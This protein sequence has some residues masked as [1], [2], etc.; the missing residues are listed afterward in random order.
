MKEH[1]KRDGEKLLSPQPY[2]QSQGNQGKLG[3][4]KVPGEDHTN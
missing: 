4:G 1:A 2:S 3:E